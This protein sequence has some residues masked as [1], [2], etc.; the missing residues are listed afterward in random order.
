[1]D[2]MPHK[3]IML[4]RKFSQKHAISMHSLLEITGYDDTYQVSEQ[5]IYNALIS[6]SGFVDDWLQYS[7]DKRCTGWYFK[8]DGSKYLVG[9]LSESGVT[10]NE[11]RYDDKL[12]ACAYFIKQELK[13]LSE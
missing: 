6:N 8:L 5:E 9:Y 1:M 10:E 4:P 11:I 2:S 12:K 7:E 13:V 3:L